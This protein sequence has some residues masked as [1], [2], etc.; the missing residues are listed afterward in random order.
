MV[1]HAPVKEGLV[2]SLLN[3]KTNSLWNIL[4]SWRNM[5]NQ[6]LDGFYDEEMEVSDIEERQRLII[7]VSSL[8]STSLFALDTLVQHHVL[9]GQLQDEVD[10]LRSLLVSPQL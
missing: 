6:D 2:I 5:D 4:G 10:Y 8:S 3:T 7:W 1:F 9:I